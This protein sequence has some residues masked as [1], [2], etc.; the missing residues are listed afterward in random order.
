MQSRTRAIVAFVSNETIKNNCSVNV[1]H[2]NI[3]I[4]RKHTMH[5]I[6]STGAMVGFK[7]SVHIK[8]TVNIKQA[9]CGL[10][11]VYYNGHVCDSTV[12]IYT[13]K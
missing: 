9:T 2:H 7:P 1:S 4:N 6:Y 12:M 5:I 11:L 13:S 3:E 8:M 10:A